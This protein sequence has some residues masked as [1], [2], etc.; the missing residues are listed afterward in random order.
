MLK[1]YTLRIFN[2]CSFTEQI[3]AYKNCYGEEYLIISYLSGGNSGGA[4]PV[5]ISNTEVKSSSVYGTARA[6][7][8]ESRS[9]PESYINFIG[10]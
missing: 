7:L 6:T 2:Y 10:V 4:T 9:L 1:Y 8:W 5:P 3:K